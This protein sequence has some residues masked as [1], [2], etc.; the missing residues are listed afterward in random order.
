M[1]C[2]ASPA[3]L[4]RQNG[5]A[6]SRYVIVRGLYTISAY[7]YTATAYSVSD[8]KYKMSISSQPYACSLNN[9]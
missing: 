3:T 4:R 6:D 7:I 9:A 5:S 8:D 1:S 2:K